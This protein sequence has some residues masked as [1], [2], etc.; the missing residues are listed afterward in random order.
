[1]R[2]KEIVLETIEAYLSTYLNALIQPSQVLNY[3]VLYHFLLALETYIARKK[4]DLI[5]LC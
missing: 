1:M 4:T 5:T 3:L 2:T